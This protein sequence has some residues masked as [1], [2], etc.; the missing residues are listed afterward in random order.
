M[1]L[2]TIAAVKTLLGI[3]NTDQ[4]ALLTQLLTAADAAVKT[5]IRRGKARTAFANWPE[6]GADTAFLSGHGKQDLILPYWPVTA[7]AS[8]YLDPTGYFGDGSGAFAAG[9]L[10]SA[11]SDYVLVRDDGSASVSGRLRKLSGPGSMVFDDHGW[12]PPS[13]SSGP[14][15][16]NGYTKPVWTAGAGNIKVTFTAGYASVPA[17]L[18]DAVNQLCVFRYANRKSAG[19]MQSEGLGDYH[20]ALA[21]QSLGTAPELGTMRQL[22]ARYREI[23]I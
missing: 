12:W 13:G 21:S 7:V 18:A 1:A 16:L 23:C 2:S 4:D 6:T 3:G 15:A 19:P 8:V 11:G 22:L 14:L 20:Y 5:Y 17:D 9:T 10:L